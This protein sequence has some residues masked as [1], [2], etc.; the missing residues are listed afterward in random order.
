MTTATKT[1]PQV[2]PEKIMQIGMAFWPAKTL[3]SAV[4]LGVF[5]ELAKG[6]R[7]LA[8]L[9]ER[10][11]LHGRG[12]ADFF[13]TLVALGFLT[14]QDGRYANA[15]DSE[16]FLDKAKPSYMGGL[17][18]MA[19]SRLYPFWGGLTKALKTGEPQNEVAHGQQDLFDQLFADPKRMKEFCT[20]MTGVSLGSAHAIAK[21]FDWTPYKT[22]ADIGTMQG[23]LPVA[24]AQAN[25]HLKGVGADLPII[26]PI[27]HEYVAKAGVSDRLSFKPCDFFKQDLPKADVI[28]MGH[29]LHDWDLTQK[30][31]LMKKAYEAL[32]KGGAYIVYEALIDDDRSQNAFGLL[33]SLNMLI[34]TRGGFDYTGA[35][36]RGWM[37]EAGF[38]TIRVEHLAG[39][40]SMVVGIK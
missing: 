20:A 39:P 11:G 5:S 19:N 33:M 40:E 2:T 4:E 21:K 22:F 13:D 36:C 12:A 3:L 35:D 29:I 15:P 30:R 1:A 28:V 25:P 7:D 9:T 37:K 16:V 38:S 26:E 18:E 10:F 17:L 8:Q 31:M 27:F 23:A 6:P 14:R 34:E 32:P 24:V